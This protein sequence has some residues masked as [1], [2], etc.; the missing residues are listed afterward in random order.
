MADE[1]LGNR[2]RISLV[3][4]DSHTIFLACEVAEQVVGTLDVVEVLFDSVGEENEFLLVT[5]STWHENA[6]HLFC[7][8]VVWGCRAP[9][10]DS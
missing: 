10:T 2:A 4:M 7:E 8:F 9:T 5:E 3:A 1:T 6:L